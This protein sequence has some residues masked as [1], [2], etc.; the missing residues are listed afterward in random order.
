M[1]ERIDQLHDRASASEP[2]STLPGRFTETQKINIPLHYALAQLHNFNTSRSTQLTSTWCLHTVFITN[3]RMQGLHTQYLSFKTTLRTVQ[4]F[5][6]FSTWI[7]DP[8]FHFSS[9]LS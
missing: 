8:S 1:Q 2:T 3:K 4:L 6:L 9:L 5:C 7:T